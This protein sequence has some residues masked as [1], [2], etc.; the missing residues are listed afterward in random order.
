M[1]HISVPSSPLHHLVDDQ[2]QS[3]RTAPRLRSFCVLTVVQRGRE[4]SLADR[5]NLDVVPL[6]DQLASEATD[7]IWH[8]SRFGELTNPLRRDPKSGAHLGNPDELRLIG[9]PT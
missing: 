2:P 1:T 8:V 3:T 7:G 5:P 4:S 6:P 9:C